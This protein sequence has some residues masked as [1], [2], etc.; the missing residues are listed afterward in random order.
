[1]P[2]LAELSDSERGDVLRRATWRA[3][4]RWPTWAGLVAIP[5]S[6]YAGSVI[7]STIGHQGAGEAAGTIVGALIWYQVVLEVTRSVV[8]DLVERQRRQ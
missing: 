3:F 1:M 6:G 8:R 4:G 2:E 7:G 5:L